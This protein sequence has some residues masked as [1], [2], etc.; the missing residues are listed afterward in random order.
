MRT[1]RGFHPPDSFRKSGGLWAVRH[2]KPKLCL[3]EFFPL[4]FYDSKWSVSVVN[5]ESS[6]LG[7]TDTTLC[8]LAPLTRLESLLS[9]HLNPL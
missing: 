9:I 6:I 5:L 3:V 8:F 1:P 4:E 7:D 2:G